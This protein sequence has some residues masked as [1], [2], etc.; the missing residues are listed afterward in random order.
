MNYARQLGAGMLTTRALR[1][2]RRRHGP[3]DGVLNLQQAAGNRA[4][5]AILARQPGTK[6]APKE[7]DKRTSH[8]LLPDIG[9]IELLSFQWGERTRGERE[10]EAPRFRELSLTTTSGKHSNALLRAAATGMTSRTPVGGRRHPP[11]ADRREAGQL[12]DGRRRRV[13]QAGG[14]VDAQ[15]R[16]RQAG[17]HPANGVAAQSESPPLT[18]TSTATSRWSDDGN[19][20]PFGTPGVNSPTSRNSGS[21][22]S[23]QNTNESRIASRRSGST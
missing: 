8:V 22:I 23:G 12:H 2:R 18:S 10:E 14:D 20:L 13:G 11:E 7:Q 9:R 19:P 4:V 1:R 6:E 5:G 15:L 17:V 16:R 21:L 3:Q